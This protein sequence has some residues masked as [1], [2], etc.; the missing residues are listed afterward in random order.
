MDLQSHFRREHASS[1]ATG[2]WLK[3]ENQTLILFFQ[4]DFDVKK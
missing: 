1:K 3:C 2:S 4:A